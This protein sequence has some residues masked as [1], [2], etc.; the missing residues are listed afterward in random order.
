MEYVKEDGKVMDVDINK[1]A[2]SIEHG[3]EIVAY[4]SSD[5]K[6]NFSVPNW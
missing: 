6:V 5:L 2:C 3:E 1:N 4:E